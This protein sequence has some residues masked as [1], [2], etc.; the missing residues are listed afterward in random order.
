MVS[1]FPSVYLLNG[2]L[3]LPILLWN[4]VFATKLPRAFSAEYFEKDIPVFLT[5][6]E[7]C[8]RLAVFI[9]PLFMP[10]SLTTQTQKLGL[11][12]YVGGAGIYFLSWSALIIFPESGW[13]RSAAGFLAPAYTPLLW[14]TGIGL[15]GSS[16]YSAIPSHAGT[17][18][19]PYWPGIY[20]LSAILFT[21]VHVAHTSIV[22]LKSIG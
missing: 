15:L 22:Y 3:L 11:G 16:L 8:L 21:G 12:L 1:L 4:W 2:L 14:L 19:I 18:I 13:S 9:L 20:L 7:N 5:W 10:L 6:A 17:G